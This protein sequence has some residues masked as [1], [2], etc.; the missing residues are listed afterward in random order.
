MFFGREDENGIVF[1]FINESVLS[2]NS[3]P[4]GE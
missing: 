1:Y 4:A 2:V 3:A